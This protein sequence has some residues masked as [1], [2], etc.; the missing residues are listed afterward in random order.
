M[1]ALTSFGIS[2]KVRSDREKDGKAPLQATIT[3]NGQKSFLTLPRKIPVKCWNPG[4]ALAR[5]NTSEGREINSYIE[6]VRQTI[7]ECYRDLQLERKIITPEVIKEVFLGN[8]EKEHTLDQISAYHNEMSAGVLAPGTMKNYYTTQR[9]MREFV[10]KKYRRSEYCLSEL[11]YK[12]ILDLEIF[13]RNHQPVDHQKPLTNNGIM[14]HL[15]R[16]KKMIN[17]AFRLGWISRDPFEKFQL[18]FNKVEKEYLTADELFALEHKDVKLSRLAVVRDIFVFCCYTGLAFV[19]VM[20]LA[21][22]HIVKGQDGE[23]WINTC[24]QKTTIEVKVPLLEQPLALI[25][26]YRGNIKAISKGTIFPQLTN[27]KMNSYLKELAD[28]CGIT[29]VL[30]FHVARHTFATTVTLVNGVPMETVSKLLGHATMRS[31]QVYAKVVEKKVSEDMSD[32]KQ[33]LEMRKN[34]IDE[35]TKLVNVVSTVGGT[36]V[37]QDARLLLSVNSG[38]VE[39]DTHRNTADTDAFSGLAA[40]DR[41]EYTA[42]DQDVFSGHD[43]FRKMILGAF[44]ETKE[45]IAPILRECG[46]FKGL[47]ISV[48]YITYSEYIQYRLGGEFEDWFDFY[49]RARWS[50]ITIDYFGDSHLMPN[51]AAILNNS[52]YLCEGKF[53]VDFRRIVFDN[54]MFRWVEI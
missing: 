31:T 30:T 38:I 29:K 7:G 50:V 23:L 13:L 16:L 42:N 11:N 20:N 4:K 44:V 37:G 10:K 17:L 39:D 53:R 9:Y 32:L 48:D 28:I 24:R 47:K 25:E 52:R 40:I 45:W 34:G 27:Q 51:A 46:K 35:P 6:E 15:E 49:D 33:R 22:G 12:F 18:K 43:G 5:A 26:Q 21:P 19:D 3:V 41:S 14:K 36:V 1:K 8:T 2:F 54:G